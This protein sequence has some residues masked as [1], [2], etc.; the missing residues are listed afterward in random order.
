[1]IWRLARLSSTTIATIVSDRRARATLVARNTG[2]ICG[3]PLA[4]EAFRQLDPKAT[5]RVESEDGFR[6]KKGDPV[7]FVTNALSPA[8]VQRVTIVDDAERV[9]EVVVE[10]KQLSLAIGK[11]G[12]NVRYA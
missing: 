8:K 4:L 2:T 9:M 12:Q 11:K 7:L 10:D 5:I 1:M 6:L 3:V